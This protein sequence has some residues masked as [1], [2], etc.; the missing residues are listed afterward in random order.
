MLLA[1]LSIIFVILFAVWSIFS[2]YELAILA[3][4]NLIVGGAIVLRMIHDLRKRKNI[5]LYFVS[6]AV[7]TF[8][9]LFKD[10]LGI[11]TLSRILSKFMILEAVQIL[12]LVFVIAQ[13]I[14]AVD[15]KLR[16]KKKRSK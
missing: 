12:A 10:S 4:I 11:D 6:I 8:L 5:A 15:K 14:L 7:S 2:L 3:L 1:I 9:V 16:V 13:A